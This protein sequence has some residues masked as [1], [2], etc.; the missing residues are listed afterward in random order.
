M[1]KIDKKLPI[2]NVL[3]YELAKNEQ[4][5]KGDRISVMPTVIISKTPNFIIHST[6][7]WNLSFRQLAVKFTG[8][9]HSLS[10]HTFTNYWMDMEGT[11]LDMF[12]GPIWILA[13]K[14]QT[15]KIQSQDKIPQLKSE[16]STSW[17]QVKSAPTC[18]NA[19]SNSG[20]QSVE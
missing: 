4:K 17:T 16:L 15:A 14:D 11:C 20:L 3:K 2:R 8:Y 5:H 19:R 9:N 6:C 13:G 1:I 7:S 18:T 10:F 12:G